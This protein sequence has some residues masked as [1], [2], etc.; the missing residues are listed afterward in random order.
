MGSVTGWP[1]FERNILRRIFG[2]VKINNQCRS[3]NNNELKQ[4][5]DDLDIVS[6]IRIS[7]LKW[8]GHVNRMDDKLKVK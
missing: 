1:F 8:I 4:L 2:A 5:Y 7:R 3:R 6:F